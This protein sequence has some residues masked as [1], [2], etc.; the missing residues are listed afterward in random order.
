MIR[1]GVASVRERARRALEGEG[2]AFVTGSGKELLRLCREREI[3]VL[4]LDMALRDLDGRAALEKLK[5]AGAWV[6]PAAAALGDGPEDWALRLSPD[7]GT[8]DLLAAVSPLLDGKGGLRP[9]YRLRPGSA[10]DIPRALDE[11]GVP[12]RLRGRRCMELALEY[13]LRDGRL[14]GNLAGRLFPAVAEAMGMSPGGAERALRTAMENAW[15]RPSYGLFGNVVDPERGMPT[16]GEFL[17]QAAV[18]LREGR[19]GPARGR[20]GG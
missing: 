11:L 2:C 9:K 1:W 16:P 10:G 8:A 19:F 20:A 4:A 18:A 12:A 13:I 17:S 5:E 6:M 7:A 15:K 3:D 14:A